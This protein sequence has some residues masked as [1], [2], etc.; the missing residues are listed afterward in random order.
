M[1]VGLSFNSVEQACHNAEQE[2]GNDWNFEGIVKKARDAWN[3]KLNR[4]QLDPKTQ[5]HIAELFYSSLYYSF[6]TPNNATGEAGRYFPKGHSKPYYASLYCTWDTYRTFFPFLSLTSA[7]DYADIV[8]NYVDAWRVNGW[9]PECRANNVPGLTQSGSH[10]VMVIGDYLAKYGDAVKKGLLP[11]NIKDAY[12]AVY[13]DAY[14]TPED[15][16]SYGRQVG[17]YAQYGY[18]PFGVFDTYSTGRQT[19]ETARTVEYAHNDFGARTVALVAGH[20]DVA[21][22]LGKRSLNYR[23]TFDKSVKSMGFS[24][25]VQQRR[26]DGSFRHVD[27][28]TCSPIDGGDHACSLQQENNYGVYETS[29]W[30]YSLYAPHD[31]AGLIELLTS[32]K[33]NSQGARDL[34]S[35]RLDKFFDAKLFYPGNEPSFQTPLLY[36]YINAPVKSIK[37][38]RNVVYDNFNTTTGGLPG[39]SDSGAT[40]TLLLFHLLGLYPVPVTKELLISSPFM[41]SYDLRNDFHGNTH[42]QVENFDERT[43]QRDIP[44]GARAYVEKVLIN[45]KEHSSRCKIQ[46]DELFG[47]APPGE[48]TRIITLV[49]TDDEH[50]ANSCGQNE[51]EALPA[52]LSTG[53]FR[54]F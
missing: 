16:N 5:P 18:V 37:R 26:P 53:G 43:L 47:P 6:L 44:P 33:S 46:F 41:P 38:I 28:I 10:G 32:Q 13:K 11:G 54:S 45:G 14:V 2:I 29:S 9:V 23:N 36:H 25:F 20:K 48:K 4:I 42:V 39:N 12:D 22:S 21:D 15:W 8:E 34:F 50:K 30:E 27:P 19:R 1:R 40:N 3:V 31:N 7:Y 51:N 35:R 17:V 24:N 52:S 49:M